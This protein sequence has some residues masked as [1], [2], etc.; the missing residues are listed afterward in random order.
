MTPFSLL[1]PSSQC[2]TIGGAENHKVNVEKNIR[3]K[4]AVYIQNVSV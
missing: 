1:V 3:E 2:Y 4:K